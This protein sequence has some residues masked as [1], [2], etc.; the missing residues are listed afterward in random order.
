[1]M[2][3]STLVAATLTTLLVGPALADDKAK[4]GDD[5][6]FRG[7]VQT[8]RHGDDWRG[9]DRHYDGWHGRYG[10]FSHRW[11]HIPPPYYRSSSGYRVG[12]ESGWRDAAQNCRFDYRPGRWYRDPRE[13]Y[14]YFGFQIDG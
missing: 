10:Q 3:K 11:R 12:Y 1:M 14:W 8:Y 7:Q 9:D 5:Y 13:S 6:R 2:I 4:H